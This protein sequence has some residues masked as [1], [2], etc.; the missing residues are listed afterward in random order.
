MKKIE[1]LELDVTVPRECIARQCPGGSDPANLVDE[2]IRVRRQMDFSHR[3]RAEDEQRHT[4]TRG[5]DVLAVEVR[6]LSHGNLEA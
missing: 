2:S 1:V 5:Q 6:G 4:V 3:G